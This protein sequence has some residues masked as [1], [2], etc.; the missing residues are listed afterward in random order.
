MTQ[1]LTLTTI[2]GFDHV[3]IMLQMHRVTFSSVI[4]VQQNYMAVVNNVRFKEISF[5]N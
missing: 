5:Q 1:F 4:I 2:N 3:T